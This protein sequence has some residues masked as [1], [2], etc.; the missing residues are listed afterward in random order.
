MVTHPWKLPGLPWAKTGQKGCVHP[1]LPPLHLQ[2]GQSRG[3]GGRNAFLAWQEETSGAPT[4]PV[5]G[6][7]SLWVLGVV[8]TCWA[9]AL[10]GSRGHPS[11][12]L[13]IN[14]PHPGEGAAAGRSLTCLG[15]VSVPPLCCGVRRRPQKG[16]TGGTGGGGG[17]V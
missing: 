9:G 11:H 10:A 8:Q 13:P 4:P 14:R 16:S 12:V 7:G 6:P 2:A 5:T 3:S 1:G 17:G 15:L